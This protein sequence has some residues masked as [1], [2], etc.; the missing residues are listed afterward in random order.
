M[1]SRPRNSHSPLRACCAITYQEGE[2][3]KKM[4][5][6]TTR[7]A[8]ATAS[9]RHQWSQ[10]SR[11]GPDSGTSSSTTRRMSPSLINKAR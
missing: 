9:E 7:D 10:T 11:I 6:P 1:R 2:R 8:A 4:E 3:A 5:N